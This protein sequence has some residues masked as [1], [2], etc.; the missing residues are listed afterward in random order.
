M[1]ADKQHSAL[2][3]IKKEQLKRRVFSVEFKA[4]VVRYKKAE[5]QGAPE[6]GRKFEVLPKLIRNWEKQ[7]DAGQLTIR[8]R[9]CGDRLEVAVGTPGI[10]ITAALE[11]AQQCVR[12]GRVIDD[13]V[14]EALFRWKATEET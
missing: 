8:P 5:N 7:Y 9:A 11:A 1:K 12:D 14:M 6:G 2:E 3:V 10:S 4:E 13:E